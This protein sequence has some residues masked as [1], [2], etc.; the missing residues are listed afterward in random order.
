MFG[1][2]HPPVG[3]RARFHQKAEERNRLQRRLAHSG[4]KGK[5]D[6]ETLFGRWFN[7]ETFQRE[8]LP[9]YDDSDGNESDGDDGPQVVVLNP[10]RDLT[11]EE[12]E[13]EKLRLEKGKTNKYF[14]SA[15]R[16]EKNSYFQRKLKNPQIWQRKLFSNRRKQ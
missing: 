10:G 7:F 16:F 6:I 11:K 3:K 13:A 2:S 4:H 5:V 9:T 1:A 14:E 15:N 8:D 12:A